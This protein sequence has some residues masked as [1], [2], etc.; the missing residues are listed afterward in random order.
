[1]SSI[2]FEGNTYTFGATVSA[3][4]GTGT[5]NYVFGGL[6][7]GSTYGFIIW[8]FNSGGTSSIAGPVNLS[9]LSIAPAELR[10]SINSYMWSWPVS[11]N[12]GFDYTTGSDTNLF[13][14][15]EDL[16]TAYWGYADHVRTP[17]GITLPNGYTSGKII[18]DPSGYQLIEQAHRLPVGSTFI[19]SWY[20][21]STLGSAGTD[22]F[23]NFYGQGVSDIN[24]FYQQQ[25]LPQ[26][27]TAF[28]G[29]GLLPPSMGGSLL[30][31]TA[32]QSGWIRYAM[33]VM[34]TPAN[35]VFG[36]LP[37]TARDILFQF[38]LNDKGFTRTFYFGAP[39]LELVQ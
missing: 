26:L 7:S 34:I 2:I 30:G 15:S 38:R 6:S 28:I 27:G 22:L 4:P 16:G 33:L 12:W 10:D 39:Q 19:V 25:L 24:T 1:M 18:T 14:S 20:Q 17:S 32:G 35:N 11:M 3:N 36:G 31:P 23:P 29:T 5:T 13:Y 8:A 37:M 21:H 9:T